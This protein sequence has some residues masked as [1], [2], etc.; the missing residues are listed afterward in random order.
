MVMKFGIYLV[1][2]V[3]NVM[4]AHPTEVGSGYV[5]GGAAARDIIANESLEGRKNLYK[6]K[7]LVKTNTNLATVN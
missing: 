1:C 4:M 2:I 3:C 7:Y 5:R 6:L